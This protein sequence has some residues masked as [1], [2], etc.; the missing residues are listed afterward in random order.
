MS[1][2]FPFPIYE[3]FVTFLHIRCP[4]TTT[5]G[6]GLH[7]PT[8]SLTSECLNKFGPKTRRKSSSGGSISPK[9]IIPLRRFVIYC[10]VI[11][12]GI[13]FVNKFSVAGSLSSMPL[14]I[15]NRQPQTHNIRRLH[16]VN[17]RCDFFVSFCV[18]FSVAGSLS[19]AWFC[20]AN[21]K[22]GNRKHRTYDDYTESIVDVIS[23]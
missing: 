23:L 16:G 6:L 8:L 10:G 1:K 17:R 9:G 15:R 19:W 2:K 4:L 18:N 11:Y 3:L 20:I 21:K 22:T 12:C 7:F 5:L 13:I 14:T